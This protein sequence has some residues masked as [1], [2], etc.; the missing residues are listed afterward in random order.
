M[1]RHDVAGVTPEDTAAAHVSDLEI[2]GDFGVQFLS[3]WFDEDSQAVFCLARAP[4]SDAVTAV[5][6]KS[7]GLIPAEIIEVAEDDVVRFLGR[8]TDPKDASEVSSPF[9]TVVFT[10]LDRSTELLNALG[11]SRFMLLLTEHDLI[12][13]KGLVRFKGREVK[14]TGDGIMAAFTDVA[15]A[16]SWCLAV[17]DEFDE[18]E[19]MDV[20]IGLA[21]GE[22]VDHNDDLYGP[23][24][25]LAR[26]LCDATAA[27]HVLASDVVRE[28][29]VRAGFAFGPA[30]SRDLK[31]FPK[32]VS[33]FE[34]LH[35]GQTTGR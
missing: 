13:R 5:H 3:Y 28:L 27:G 16:L 1:D 24:V 10:D 21:A 2:A 11:Q 34:L 15:R 30:Q 20:R 18:R 6:E 26:R 12:L 29:G 4:Q 19:D 8:V 14:H 7:H 35:A 9:R 31:G 22:P 25:N 17:R 33:I 23:S 32:T